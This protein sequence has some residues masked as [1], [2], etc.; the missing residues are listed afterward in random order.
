[1]MAAG[2]PPHTLPVELIARAASERGYVFADDKSM[3]L[4][5]EIALVARSSASVLVTGATGTGKEIVARLI[6][7]FS[8]RGGQ[9]IVAQCGAISRELFESLF[10]GHVEGAF[11]GAVRDHIGYVE[12]AR[13]GT[14]FL[15]EVGELPLEHQQKLLRVLDGYDFQPVGGKETRKPDVRV[16]AATHRDL[17]A[18]RREGRFRDDLYGRLAVLRLEVPPLDQRPKDVVAVAQQ[19]AEELR[20]GDA[21]FARGVAGAARRLCGRRGAWPLGMRQVLAFIEHAHCFGVDSAEER[22]LKEW[23]LEAGSVLEP[24]P[25]YV[26]ARGTRDHEALTGLIAS[27]W[28]E[29][30]IGSEQ[31]IDVLASSLARALLEQP[32]VPMDEIGKALGRSDRRTSK[33]YLEPLAT[34]GLVRAQDGELAGAKS[35]ELLWPPVS[36]VLMQRRA[37]AWV[38]IPPDYIPTLQQGDRLCVHVDTQI[39]L[40]LR[41][42]VVTHSLDGAPRVSLRGR[43]EA[44]RGEPQRVFI[45][46]DDSPGFEQI[47]VHMSWM[48]HKGAQEVAD[49]TDAL[50]APGPALLT[51]ERERLTGQYGPGWIKEFL[52]HHV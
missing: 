29:Q 32:I 25:L 40:M 51:R 28:H 35:M 36:A 38:P 4:L 43:K 14:L 5:Q 42:V 15:D 52:V 7:E 24:R 50:T 3:Q 31:H 44:R 13:A 6:H 23:S 26:P 30:K 11:S 18:L 27:V 12:A 45:E 9:F 17:G 41:V 49:E 22:M 19:K 39:D 47:L 21:L 8:G 20:P 2:Y 37:G 46:L 1:M 48:P 10:F 33:K 34:A 16:I